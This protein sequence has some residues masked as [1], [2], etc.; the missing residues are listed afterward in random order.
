M[1][2]T[3][4]K[5]LFCDFNG[6]ISY[7]LFWS[8]YAHCNASLQA[9]F[10]TDLV[11]EWMK[12]RKTSEEIN[13]IFADI[14]SLEYEVVMADFILDCQNL[15]IDNDILRQIKAKIG[16]IKILA[17]NNMDCFDRWVIPSHP[18]LEETFDYI[19][20]SSNLGFLKQENNY[21]D[22]NNKLFNASNSIHIDDSQTICD[23]ANSQNIKTFCISG[24]D[25]VLQA[26][27]QI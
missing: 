17:T 16:Y 3:N 10:G 18:E 4:N 25:N 15:D 22:L 19:H 14:S 11:N 12:G 2:K 20:N 24:V 27:K 21:F 1:N 7:N 8:K 9:I 6:V 23:I 26:L 13:R 5:I